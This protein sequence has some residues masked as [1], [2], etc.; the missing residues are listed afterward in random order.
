MAH[1]FRPVTSSPGSVQ[2]R[3]FDGMG[4]LLAFVGFV[5]IAS[6]LSIGVA[7][8]VLV[9][10][11]LH[12]AGRVLAHW[13]LGH[14]QTNFRFLPLITGDPISHSQPRDD[15]EL[16]FLSLMGAGLSLA[17]M[18]LSLSLWQVLSENGAPFSGYFLV[19]G[20][21][22]GA[23]NFLLL[24]PFWRLPGRSC[25]DVV[26]RAFWPAL[27]PGMAAFLGAAFLAAGLRAGSVALLLIGAYG[28]SS[29][30]RKPRRGTAAMS[31]A[32]ALIALAAYAFTLAAHF[33]ATMMLVQAIL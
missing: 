10:L 20:T 19:F 15:T 17:P 11:G 25:A 5:A 9:A 23:V 1:S 31:S 13:M 22:L 24:L 30:F 33:G 3:G 4:V 14:G 2:L 8:S 6:L 28:I 16:A 27:A 21:S 12:E 18:A 32:D 26:S 7:A 29:I